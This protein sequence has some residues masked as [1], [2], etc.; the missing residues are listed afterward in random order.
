MST[1]INSY[2]VSLALNAQDYIKNSALARS[3]TATLRRAI[4]DAK[5]PM[6]RYAQTYD[7]LEKALA[8]NTISLGT[9]KR[10]LDEAKTKAGLLATEVQKV[11]AA[12]THHTTALGKVAA[13]YQGVTS[14]LSPLV[15]LMGAYVGFATAKKAVGLA[16]SA[17][18]ASVQ[19]EVLTG[20]MDDSLVLMRELRSFSEKSPI[21][22]SG[23]Q[24][25]AKTMLS[26]NVATQDV[27]PTVKMLGDVVGGN[28]ERFGQI[29]LAYSQMSAAG[30]LMGQDLLQ[31]IN[32]GFNP[33]QEIS[34]KTGESMLALKQR[35][36]D[37]GISSQEVALA[38][39]TATA[40]GGKFHGMTERLATTV[41]GQLNIAMSDL[42]K[43]GERLGTTLGPLAA[44]FAKGIADATEAASPLLWVI[45]KMTDGLRF[46]VAFAKDAGTIASDIAS[47][48]SGGQGSGRTDAMSNI[49]SFLDELDARPA[50]AAAK[51]AQEKNAKM[52][53]RVAGDKVDTSK[54]ETE[55]IKRATE[56]AKLKLDTEK[57]ALEVAKEK[58]AQ[59][60]RAAK[61]AE[62]QRLQAFQNAQKYFEAERRR[63]IE[64]QRQLR[65][66]KIS[67]LEAGS[68]G[69][70]SYLQDQ[71]NQLRFSRQEAMAGMSQ[72]TTGQM[73]M[74]SAKQLE[75]LQMSN[76]KQERMVALL[77]QVVEESKNNGFRRFR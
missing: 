36:E 37:G 44:D 4:N 68:E 33:L 50:I 51:A 16:I 1:V 43:S 7:L 40:E 38:F 49:N 13:G 57:K 15:S 23:A 25:A 27:I 26:F 64:H 60:D 58:K 59:E 61:A 9:Y 20:S 31:M 22:F 53:E 76:A 65:S 12:S 28:N 32:A 39:Q 46:V 71:R 45:Q 34:R 18:D 54:Q 67:S 56:A 14:K 42:Q 35:M 5:S 66:T 55:A 72:P 6:E 21:T 30:R 3:E 77:G 19:F 2:S 24:Q 69:A 47:K 17:E 29:T 73:V 52:S 48:M 11:T 10:L 8:K 74:E 75:A 63:Q 70:A 62:N 41:G